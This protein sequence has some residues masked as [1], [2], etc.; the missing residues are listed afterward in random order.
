M[1]VLSLRQSVGRGGAAW[2]EYAISKIG[3][4]TTALHVVINPACCRVPGDETATRRSLARMLACLVVLATMTGCGDDRPVTHTTPPPPTSPSAS[5]NPQDRRQ[6]ANLLQVYDAFNETLVTLQNSSDVD[7]ARA[8]L[9]TYTVDPLRTQLLLDLR[10]RR[11]ARL[12]TTGKP[13]WT[14][15]VARIDTAKTPFTA[16][17]ESCYNATH[18][19]LVHA[20]GR[21]AG[22]PGQAKK[23]V[24]TATATVFGDGK[25]Y[26]QTSE[27][28]R[29]RTC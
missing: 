15:K 2:Y 12:H 29:T 22:V 11:D 20:D 27:A 3:R 5:D 7:K 9:P 19:D 17:I 26:L 13:A 14:A 23:Y 24:V 8:E 1:P 21:P 6:A 10:Q 4:A 28:D 16:T 18:Y 25:W